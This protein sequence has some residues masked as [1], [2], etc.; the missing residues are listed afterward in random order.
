M[1]DSTATTSEQEL[2][3]LKRE[4]ADL[5]NSGSSSSSIDS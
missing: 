5:A 2:A 3:E 1:G 4:L